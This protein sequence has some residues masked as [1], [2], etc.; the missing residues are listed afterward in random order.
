MPILIYYMASGEVD[1]DFKMPWE[2][3]KKNVKL[4]VDH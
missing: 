4:N 2:F 3:R 1:S